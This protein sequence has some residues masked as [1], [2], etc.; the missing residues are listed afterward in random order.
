MSLTLNSGVQPWDSAL[1]E[2]NSTRIPNAAEARSCNHGRNSSIRG[3]MNQCSAI[4]SDSTTTQPAMT[5]P[6]SHVAKRA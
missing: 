6:S 5:R 2:P 1:M 3:K 4:H